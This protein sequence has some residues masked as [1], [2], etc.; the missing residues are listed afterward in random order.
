MPQITLMITQVH[1]RAAAIAG[2]EKCV[3]KTVIGKPKENY[4]AKISS[5]KSGNR[6]PA[7][8]VLNQLGRA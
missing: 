2:G 1:K 3:S 5:R 7:Y 6:P 4:F 8:V